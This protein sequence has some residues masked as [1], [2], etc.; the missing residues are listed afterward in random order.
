MFKYLTILIKILSYKQPI[1]GYTNEDAARK[2]RFERCG[3]KAMKEVAQF[4]DLVE[5]N[6][7]FN[8][9]GIACSGE[10]T[11]MGM[12]RDGKGIYTYRS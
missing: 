5:Y 8:M 12:G 2:K 6:I 4:L 1:N 7:S 10:L 9:A 11:L 3:K